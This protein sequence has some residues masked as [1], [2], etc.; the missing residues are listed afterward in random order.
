[1]PHLPPAFRRLV[2]SN[3][4][5]QSAEQIGLAAAP[6]VAVVA[7][8]ATAA[9]TGWLQTAQTLP[10]LALS[11]PFGLLA[12]RIPRRALMVA[13]ETARAASLFAMLLLLAGD[14][15]TLPLMAILGFVGAAGTV[16]YSIAAPALIPALVAPDA[17]AAA[18][19]RI[20]LARTVAFAGG[21]A[22]AGGLLNWLGASPAFALAAAL[23]TGA[24]VLLWGLRE[25]PRSPAPRRRVT[26]DLAEGIAFVARSP[27]L[28]PVFV[29]QVIYNTAFFIMMGV[30]APYAIRTLGLSAAQVGL[31]LSCLGIGMVT[32]AIL[33]PR[34]LH[35]VPFGTVIGIGPAC[36]VV[37]SGLMA[38]TIGMTG[39]MA[40]FAV[41]CVSFF[42]FGVGPILWTVTT[43][44]LRQRITPSAMLGRVIAIGI[45]GMGAR[46]VGAALAALIATAYGAQACLLV[47]FAGFVLQAAVIFASPAVR[48]AAQPASA[49]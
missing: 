44:T 15:L 34:L 6:I 25:P 27:L 22:L 21:P 8:G 24:A 37:A 4:L 49:V 17:M 9:E 47:A 5:A 42:L 46:P 26:A 45:F 39:G 10:L 40:A 35:A 32:G 29:T 48:L 11:I 23:S 20:E 14:W 2:W 30:H 36:A 38:A 41:I 3:L 33:A 7:L 12:D 18:N 16:A 43:T 1:M 28:R 19:T 13:A 31:T